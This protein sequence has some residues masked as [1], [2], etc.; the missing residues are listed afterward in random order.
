MSLFCE[1]VVASLKFHAYMSPVAKPI[2][3]VE[4]LVSV[5]VNPL[6]DL[7]K[8][9]LQVVGDANTTVSYLVAVQ[10]LMVSVMVN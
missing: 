6:I 8:L 10:E 2:V 4:V 1:E 5:T 3:L 7:V 9:A